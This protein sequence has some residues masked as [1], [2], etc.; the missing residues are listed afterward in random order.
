MN[1]CTH[2]ERKPSWNTMQR[3]TLE[4]FV[5]HHQRESVAELMN[6]AKHSG[7]LGVPA[8]GL[9]VALFAASPRADY[10]AA[11]FPLQSLT[12]KAE[13]EVSGAIMNLARVP[14]R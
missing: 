12:R 11:G 4:R 2:L 13:L 14:Q 6:A 9:A 10:R 7:C 8:R 3:K 5:D 1:E